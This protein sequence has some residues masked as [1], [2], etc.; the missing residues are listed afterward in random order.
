MKG[1][2][3]HLRK[4][5]KPV[6]RKVKCVDPG[7]VQGG[8]HIHVGVARGKQVAAS[9]SEPPPLEINPDTLYRIRE[10]A[11]F[12]RCRATTV[13][14]LIAN[15]ALAVIAIGPGSNGYRILGA[16]LLAMLARQ[17]RDGRSTVPVQPEPAAEETWRMMLEELGF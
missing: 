7:H 5:L 2:T 3:R 17:R 4:Q 16:D 13:R 6:A 15:D 8:G 9:A 14:D 10:V 12:L 11:R 1:N